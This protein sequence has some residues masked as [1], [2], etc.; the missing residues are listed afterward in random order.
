MGFHLRICLFFL[1]NLHHLCWSHNDWLVGDM[2]FV[3]RY[4]ISVLSWECLWCV[5]IAA[6]PNVSVDDCINHND[7]CSF[8]ALSKRAWR[9]SSLI[10]SKIMSWSPFLRADSLRTK[11]NVPEYQAHFLFM[12]EFAEKTTDCDRDSSWTS[13]RCRRDTGR[14]VQ[15]VSRR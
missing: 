2:L 11:E 4:W 13:C 8:S 9:I 14:Y 10:S 12:G 5:S 1:Q 3:A 7:A 6:P 15:A